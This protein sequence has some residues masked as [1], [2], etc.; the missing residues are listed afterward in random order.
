MC[1]PSLICVCYLMQIFMQLLKKIVKIPESG[2][3]I[4]LQVMIQLCLQ[5]FSQI[6]FL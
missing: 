5:T 6:M 2:F 1:R 4:H 3:F